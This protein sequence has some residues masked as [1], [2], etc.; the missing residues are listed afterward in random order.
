MP[1]RPRPAPA[2]AS[3]RGRLTPERGLTTRSSFTTQHGPS[4]T[5]IDDRAILP[6]PA[7]ARWTTARSPRWPALAERMP[8][9]CTSTQ[10][11][12]GYRSI[13][14]S[15]AVC[16]TTQHLMPRWTWRLLRGGGNED[17]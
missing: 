15:T 9:T 4:L 2:E 6:P 14:I 1:P 10:G 12:A 17:H 11:H 5:R 8:P 13:P 16:G 3:E 7:A